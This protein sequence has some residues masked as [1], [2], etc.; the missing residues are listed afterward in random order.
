MIISTDDD[1]KC[2]NMQLSCSTELKFK[3]EQHE[4]FTT[5]TR[6]T[7]SWMAVILLLIGVNFIFFGDVSGRNVI[8]FG[9]F[10]IIGVVCN[11]MHSCLD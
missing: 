3:L 11:S 6:T 1:K 10:G 8:S 9:S 7:F 4:L 2:L 5:F